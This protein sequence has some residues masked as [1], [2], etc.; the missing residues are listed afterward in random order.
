MSA[1]PHV[2]SVLLSHACHTVVCAPSKWVHQSQCD[3]LMSLVCL[4]SL[5]MHWLSSGNPNRECVKSPRHTVTRHAA[6]PLT[7]AIQLTAELGQSHLAWVPTTT[8]TVRALRG[9]HH[10]MHRWQHQPSNQ[11][12]PP[13]SQQQQQQGSRS[14]HGMTDAGEE[15]TALLHCCV[16]TWR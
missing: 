2:R 6:L 9:P 16:Q 5:Y 13:L 8:L 15:G 14:A 11:T 3:H 10:I 1:S 7:A 12:W 4:R